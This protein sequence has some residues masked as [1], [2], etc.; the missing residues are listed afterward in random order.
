LDQHAREQL[1]GGGRRLGR[2]TGGATT[3]FTLLEL[4]VVIAIIATL[5]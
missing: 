3:G 5:V 4:L 1:T 2:A